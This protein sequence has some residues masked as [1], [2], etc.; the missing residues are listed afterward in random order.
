MLLR[1]L[2]LLRFLGRRTLGSGSFEVAGT[3]QSRM[4]K[5]SETEHQNLYQNCLDTGGAV[6]TKKQRPSKASLNGA[7]ANPTNTVGLTAG[8][9]E[10]C[11]QLISEALV[12]PF[13]LNAS[14]TG[15]WAAYQWAFSG[16]QQYR[17]LNGVVTP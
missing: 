9:G 13:V 17:M 6:T 7:T 14:V 16:K 8:D 2:R 11:G 15:S 12:G 10:H 4:L 3:R 5:N 1:M